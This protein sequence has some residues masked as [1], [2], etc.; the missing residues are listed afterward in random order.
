[1]NNQ[2][3]PYCNTNTHMSK[4]SYN[5]LA[6]KGHNVIQ[7]L[8]V[9]WVVYGSYEL[10]QSAGIG[11]LHVTKTQS[12]CISQKKRNYKIAELKIAAKKS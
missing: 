12:A 9:I 10:S 5:V 3:G 2:V 11:D 6:R 4:Q 1:M 8:L 7:L